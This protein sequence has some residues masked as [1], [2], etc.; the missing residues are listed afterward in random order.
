MKTRCQVSAVSSSDYH[1]VALEKSGPWVEQLKEEKKVKSGWKHLKKLKPQPHKPRSEAASYGL[2]VHRPSSPLCSVIGIGGA[3][4]LVRAVG[5]IVL[6]N[7]DNR[8]W[9]LQAAQCLPTAPYQKPMTLRTAGS[10]VH[11]QGKGCPN[12]GSH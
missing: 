3:P 6:Q 1:R 5:S 9:G 2:Q 8:A 11:T 4:L 12:H 7:Y 10:Q